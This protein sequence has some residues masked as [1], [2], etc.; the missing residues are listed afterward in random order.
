MTSKRLPKRRIGGASVSAI[1]LGCFSMSGIAGMTEVYGAVDLNEARRTIDHALDCG[2]TLLDTAEA[3]GPFH[4]EELIGSVLAGRSSLPFIAT[5]FGFRYEGSLPVAVD[6][7]P[8]SI[9]AACEGSLKRLG[10][11]RIDLFY[12][13]RV[14][15][16]VPIEE[17]VGTLGALREEGKI[18]FAGLSELG[19]ETLTRAIAEGPVDAVQTEYS[20][21]ERGVEADILPLCAAHDIAFVAYSPL[22]RGFLTGQVPASSALDKT[23][24]RHQDPRFDADNHAANLAIVETL[25]QIGAELEASPAQVALAWLLH[26]HD[27]VIAIPGTKRRDRV[28][29]N[30]QAAFV[31][32]SDDQMDR[33]DKAAPAGQTAGARYNAFNMSMVGL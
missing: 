27:R 19:P 9:R 15:P 6:S 3:Y 10:V 12:Q 7:R 26:S 4:N 28:E 29:E 2:V 25:N 1:G 33:L 16:S 32:L 8:G 24:Y 23:D 5:K 30:I 21:W 18:G 11:E 13:H 20:L 31:S 17:V 14:D 22:G